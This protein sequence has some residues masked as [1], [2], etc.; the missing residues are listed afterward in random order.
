MMMVPT[1]AEGPGTGWTMM[2]DGMMGTRVVRFSQRDIDEGRIYYKHSGTHLLS[3]R[4]T[5][6]VFT[7]LCF[8]IRVT[9]ACFCQ[10]HI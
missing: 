6:E 3:D 4:F 10:I 9:H 5:F 2:E 8:M 7:H 1:P